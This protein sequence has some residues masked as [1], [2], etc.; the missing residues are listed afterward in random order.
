MEKDTFKAHTQYGDL[1]GSVS[2]DRADQNNFSDLLRERDVLK[3]GEVVK[4]ITFY[5]EGHYFSVSAFIEN[6]QGELRKERVAM[7]LEELFKTFKRFSVTLSR[8][9][10]LEGQEIHFV[11]VQQ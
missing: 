4:G 11:D 1:K 5:N 10:E 8:G 7:S 6:E 9:G 3:G 2:A